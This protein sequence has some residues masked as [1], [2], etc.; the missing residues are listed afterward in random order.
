M[1]KRVK[2]SDSEIATKTQDFYIKVAGF[3]I[4]IVLGPAEQII[5]KRNTIESIRKTWEKG[6][7][8]KT[9]S[10]IK[11]DFEIR[12]AST[13]SEMGIVEKNNGKDHYYLAVRRDFAS[14]RVEVFY[15][16]SLPALTI[17][18]K[19]I[20]SFLVKND[21][22]L[23]HASGCQ[24]KKG[25]LKLFLAPSGGGKTTAVNLL[26]KGKACVKFSDDIL[27]VRKKKEKWYFFSPPFIEK[28]IFPTKRKTKLAEMYFVRKSKLASKKLLTKKDNVLSEVLRQ[29]WVSS[30]KLEK[31]TLASAMSFVAE[32]EF[33]LLKATLNAKVM[34]KLLYED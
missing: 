31:E 12:F 23:L 9:T 26:S 27:V 28:D 17:L 11:P 29:I 22:F 15:F 16:T 20:L 21:G 18:M 4:K 32:N 33:Y 7:F 25:N 13:A 34:Q 10:S 6:G 1:N 30:G 5:F 3:T 19:E 8:L 2:Y 24:D 14:R